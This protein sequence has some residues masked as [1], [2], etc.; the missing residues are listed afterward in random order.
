MGAPGLTE[1]QV[2]AWELNHDEAEIAEYAKPGTWEYVND[3]L[4]AASLFFPGKDGERPSSAKVQVDAL[5]AAQARA[6]ARALKGEITGYG[7]N[8]QPL[9]PGYWLLHQIGEG[10]ARFDPEKVKAGTPAKAAAETRCRRWLVEEMRAGP[11][12]PRSKEEMAAEASAR[13][14]VKGRAFVRAWGAAAQEAATPAWSRPGR[15]ST[16]RI[17]TQS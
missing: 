1:R 8:G 7:R 13:F 10:D 17:D 12:A 11:D 5:D 6:Q 14:G 3:K 16:H 9:P 15:K 4:R 2:V